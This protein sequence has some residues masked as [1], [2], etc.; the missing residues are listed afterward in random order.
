[1]QCGPLASDGGVLS[2]KN[3]PHKGPSSQVNP[4]NE[5]PP[6]TDIHLLLG[7]TDTPDLRYIREG[8][9]WD[10]LVPVFLQW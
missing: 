5:D 2:P 4:R 1:M 3:R 6:D 8:V 10:N 7:R 9:L